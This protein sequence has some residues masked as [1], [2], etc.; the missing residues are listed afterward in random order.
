VPQIL[1]QC[2]SSLPV[3][4]IVI[5][6]SG[7]AQ[8]N[9]RLAMREIARQ[10]AQQTGESFLTDE[11]DDDSDSDEEPNPFLDQTVTVSLPPASHLTS[12]ISMLPTLSRPTIVV[13][14]G[15]DLFA[16]HPRQSLLYCLLDTAQSCRAGSGD[17]GLAVIGMTTRVDTINL[18]E[19]RVKSRFSGRTIRTAPPR[20]VDDWV[21]L[22][23]KTLCVPIKYEGGLQ[24]WKKLWTAA[25]EQFLE[26]PLAIEILTATFSLTR[27]VRML[28]RLL[29]RFRCSDL[30]LK[31]ASQLLAGGRRTGVEPLLSVP[32]N[33]RPRDGSELTA[34]PS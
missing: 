13:L 29:V 4:P 14:D 22:A 31:M 30:S 25:I 20:M 28:S 12:L 5:R 33:T 3:Q 6:L 21:A 2:L 24:E 9:A 27:D 19:K 18:L 23:K 17:K 10:L 1:Q 26:D 16:L 34:Q 11:G 7:W 32:Q 8:G 15:F